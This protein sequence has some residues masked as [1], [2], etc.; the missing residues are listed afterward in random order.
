MIRKTGSNKTLN[1][2]K[3]KA[4]LYLTCL[5]GTKYYNINGVYMRSGT[6]GRAKKCIQN[7][8][9]KIQKG[10]DTSLGDVQFPVSVPS[11]TEVVRWE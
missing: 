7:F 9:Y 4:F 2:C 8:T 3:Q 10:K 5:L 1:K 11:D 6:Y